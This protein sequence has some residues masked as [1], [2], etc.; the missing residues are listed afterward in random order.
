MY[1]NVP[2]VTLRLEYHS[3][4]G[5]DASTMLNHAKEWG[6]IHTSLKR[7][8]FRQPRIACSKPSYRRFGV[9]KSGARDDLA[10]SLNCDRV[11]AFSKQQAMQLPFVLEILQLSFWTARESAPEARLKSCVNRC[12]MSAGTHKFKCAVLVSGLPFQKS[13]LKKSTNIFCRVNQADRA[14]TYWPTY[15][16]LGVPCPKWLS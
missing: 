3:S 8:W 1:V 16:N 13:T 11:F 6:C 9:Y 10:S 4:S 15:Q 14:Q 12:H 5:K 2:R 7:G